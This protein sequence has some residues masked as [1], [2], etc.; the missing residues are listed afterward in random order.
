MS[1]FL[2]SSIK[3]RTKRN[4]TKISDLSH[5]INF[6]FAFLLFWDQVQWRQSCYQT[7]HKIVITDYS[8]CLDLGEDDAPHFTVLPLV[9][10]RP[11][12]AAGLRGCGRGMPRMFPQR[13]GRFQ[14]RP[15]DVADPQIRFTGESIR[16]R[17]GEPGHQSPKTSLP[18]SNCVARLSE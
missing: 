15:G 8:S 4:Q 2:L 3:R 9:A 16:P 7:W 10:G 6:L 14:G 17:H 13:R 5:T 1:A 11:G 18:N 12:T